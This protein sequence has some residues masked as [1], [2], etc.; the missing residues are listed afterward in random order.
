M[1]IG[2]M[3]PARTVQLALQTIVD[4]AHDDSDA[5]LAAIGAADDMNLLVVEETDDQGRAKA[6]RWLKV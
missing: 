3:I 4:A 2:R 1:D 6:I 5:L